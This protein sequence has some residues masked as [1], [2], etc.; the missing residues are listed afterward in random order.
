MGAWAYCHKCDGG[1][2]RPTIREAFKGFMDCWRCGTSRDLDEDDKT[3]AVDEVVDRLEKLEGFVL[4]DKR[5]NELMIIVPENPEMRRERLSRRFMTVSAL[6][7]AP[8]G[9]EADKTYSVQFR[10]DGVTLDFRG[11]P[12]VNMDGD[13]FLHLRKASSY[14]MQPSMEIE[15]V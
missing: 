11:V 7:Y 5:A 8:E 14:S 1:F 6:V 13:W 15:F 9:L 2:D 12:S 10:K 4:P 3:A